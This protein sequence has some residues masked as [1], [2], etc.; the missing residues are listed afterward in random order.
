MFEC[1]REASLATE[2]AIQQLQ[3]LQE[4]NG[5]SAVVKPW[6]HW[7]KTNDEAME[8]ANDPNLVQ[9]K[10]ILEQAIEPLTK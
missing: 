8:L 6:H 3:V 7:G 10:A 9:I 4:G 2:K 1:F 5:S